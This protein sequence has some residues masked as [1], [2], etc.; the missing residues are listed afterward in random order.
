MSA[1]V[2]R[3]PLTERTA[4]RYLLRACPVPHLCFLFSCLR[5]CSLGCRQFAVSKGDIARSLREYVNVQRS[6][7]YFEKLVSRRHLNE[8]HGSLLMPARSKKKGADGTVMQPGPGC[9]TTSAAA[10]A[11]PATADVASYGGSAASDASPST[12]PANIATGIDDRASALPPRLVASGAR[13]PASTSALSNISVVTFGS[14]RMSSVTARLGYIAVGK[15]GTLPAQAAKPAGP[16]AATSMS[17]SSAPVT[18]SG[19][20]TALGAAPLSC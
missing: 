3:L 2:E 5:A 4:S 11:P 20:A 10:A 12:S 18:G 6:Q 13:A 15:P 14:G 1:A 9:P 8:T 16:A 17:S 19:A 7:E